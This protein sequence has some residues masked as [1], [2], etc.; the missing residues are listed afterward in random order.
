MS[1]KHGHVASGGDENIFST[2]VTASSS[3]YDRKLLGSDQ[4]TRRVAPS[5]FA[6]NSYP[7]AQPMDLQEAAGSKRLQQRIQRQKDPEE[8]RGPHRTEQAAMKPV[9]GARDALEA[10]SLGQATKSTA[11]A[12]R[13]AAFSAPDDIVSQKAPPQ[14][15]YLTETFPVHKLV[16]LDF[17]PNSVL[18]TA[19]E[20][21]RNPTD[22]CI[23]NRGQT[24]LWVPEYHDDHPLLQTKAVSQSAGAATADPKARTQWKPNAG[25][26]GG[27]RDLGSQA[28]PPTEPQAPK[29]LNR[30]ALR[31][32]RWQNPAEHPDAGVK[33]SAV[34]PGAHV[35]GEL[36]STAAA[37]GAGVSRRQALIKSQALRPAQTA[38]SIRDVGG[39]GPQQTTVLQPAR[40]DPRQQ[41]RLCSRRLENE[42]DMFMSMYQSHFVNQGLLP[43][44]GGRLRSQR[45]TGYGSLKHCPIGLGIASE[46][47]INEQK[48]S[49]PLHPSVARKLA[50]T[51][52]L[53][54]TI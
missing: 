49:P 30:L 50:Q 31:R 29:P 41:K 18:P 35:P 17:P 43:E 22:G 6:Q 9:M 44:P 24:S 27:H 52:S 37:V 7:Q 54:T 23:K 33:P 47:T 28:F 10:I 1:V 42:G 3:S 26:V 45:S 21:R 51:E 32:L 39:D 34:L 15:H 36:E 13:S 48:A 8:F 4:P 25:K 19:E 40:L 46:G 11:G 2:Y 14:Y 12:S 53:R 16:E 5:G 20:R 38:F